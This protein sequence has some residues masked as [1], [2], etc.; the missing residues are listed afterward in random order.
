MRPVILLTCSGMRTVPHDSSSSGAP[1]AAG[2]TQHAKVDDGNRKRGCLKLT[3]LGGVERAGGAPVLLPNSQDPDNARAAVAKADGLL[4]TGGWEINP[5]LYGQERHPSIERIDD[6]RDAAELAVIEVA[7]QRRI[8]ILGVCRGLQLLNIVMGGSLIQDI[9]TWSQS[10]PEPR[11]GH[12]GTQHEI[13]IEPGSVLG[14]LLG[15]RSMVNSRHHQAVGRLADGLSATA[16]TADGIVE[17][18]ES[19]T[20]QPLLAVQWHPEDLWQTDDKFLRPFQ[21][22]VR[23]A[24]RD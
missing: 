8:P 15:G 10:R 13:A 9:P 11:V 21:W 5:S 23:Q 1:A 12:S 24:R 17:A 7:L 4:L 22:L 16:R 18:A 20:G 3:Y 2:P 19:K 6:V 14:S